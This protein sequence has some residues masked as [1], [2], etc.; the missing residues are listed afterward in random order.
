M[1]RAAYYSD[2]WTTIYHGEAL[3]VMAELAAGSVEMFAADPPYFRV[4][5]AEWDDQWGPD[6]KAFLEWIGLVLDHA[7]RLT[8]DR[9]S[10]AM[11]CAPDLSAGIELE[12]RR[13][14]N[15]LNH[16]VWR[17]PVG[18]LGR[19]DKSTM[20]RFFPTSERLIIGE[21]ARNPDGD[22]FR[23]VDHVKYRVA[24]EIYAPIR[25][26]LVRLRDLAGLTNRDV[27][28]AL[29][30]AGMA[31]HYF[32][33]SQW[34]IPTE[35]AWAIIAELMRRR[36]VTA[37]T[38]PELRAQYEE[39]RRPFELA[40]REFDGHRREF[41]AE[42]RSFTGTPRDLELLSD[43]WTFP[44]VAGNERADHPTQK[45]LALMAHLLGTLT[46]SGDTVLDPF[47]GTGTT[48]RAAKNLGRRSIG[49]EKD[50]RWCEHAARRLAQEVLQFDP[51]PELGNG[52]AEAR[53][54]F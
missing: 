17:K 35:D 44:T 8:V 43:V 19:M 54:L 26:E 38:W 37:P 21:Q 9:G 25:L 33:A 42:R 28:D 24:E 18:R 1:T 52:E 23:F 34:C 3:E 13:R 10:V 16:V 36:G 32:G 49:I 41:E 11:F 50:E 45:P 2:E 22:L 6:V 40:R 46:R 48:L 30:T 20:R 4:V 7:Q 12:F 29:G 51:A 31:G 27:D 39:L 47:M 15:V 14:L 5:D 53:A